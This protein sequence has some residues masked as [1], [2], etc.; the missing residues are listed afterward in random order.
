MLK[1]EVH[2]GQHTGVYGVFYS[3][4]FSTFLYEFWGGNI[5]VRENSFVRKTQV[6]RE[7]GIFWEKINV[8]K[9]AFVVKTQ[10]RLFVAPIFINA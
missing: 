9:N 2:A 4:Y 7:G 10:V 6:T 1:P 3:T 8:L 5:Y